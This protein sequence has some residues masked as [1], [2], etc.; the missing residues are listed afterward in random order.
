MLNKK[1]K[2]E[3]LVAIEQTIS[4]YKHHLTEIDSQTKSSPILEYKLSVYRQDEDGD[5]T[6]AITLDFYHSTYVQSLL[7]D[8]IE[9]IQKS[10]LTLEEEA[11][12]LIA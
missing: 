9:G 8:Y 1:Q 6:R 2:R 4:T 11:E 7:Q 5:C 10:I 3:R 12:D